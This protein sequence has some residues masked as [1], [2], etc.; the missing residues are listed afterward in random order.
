MIKRTLTKPM[1]LTLDEPKLNKRNTIEEYCE[2][3]LDVTEYESEIIKQV[4][5][6]L[7]TQ[8][9]AINRIGGYLRAMVDMEVIPSDR[10][11]DEYTITVKK[12]L[13]IK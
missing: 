6:G 12:I 1:R 10:V 3:L 9:E 8:D 5:R 4:K 13:E 2:Q 7:V 11:S